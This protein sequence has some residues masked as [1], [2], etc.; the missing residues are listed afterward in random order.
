MV[1]YKMQ[2][3]DTKAIL[4]SSVNLCFC[5]KNFENTKAFYTYVK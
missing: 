4:I 1:F 5:G 2:K 3:M